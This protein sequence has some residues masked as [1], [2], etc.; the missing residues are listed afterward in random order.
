M[1]RDPEHEQMPRMELEKLQLQRLQVKVREVYERVPFYRQA[2]KEKG[3]TPDDIRMLA[4]LNRLPFTSKLN[5][6][7][8]YPF[9]LM[10]VPY[11]QVVRIHSSS[12]TTGKPIIAPYTQ[13]DINT[14]AEIMARTL[15]T[16]GATSDDVLQNAYGYG[17]FTGGLGFH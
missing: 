2:F 10:A 11:K 4:D 14:W 7:D 13:G 9:G 5:F 12:G 3:V 17:L 8:N 15:A 1:I 16:G 6:R